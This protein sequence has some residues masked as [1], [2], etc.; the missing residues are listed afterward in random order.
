VRAC[1]QA[2]LHRNEAKKSELGS[3][4]K[5]NWVRQKKQE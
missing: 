3:V 5:K 4:V 1:A 2:I